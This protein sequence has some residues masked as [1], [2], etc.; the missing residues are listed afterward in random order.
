M[1]FRRPGRFVPG[2]RTTIIVE[3]TLQMTPIF[4]SVSECQTCSRL[5]LGHL[6]ASL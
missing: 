2:S 1:V 3:S 5:L 4:A 6:A